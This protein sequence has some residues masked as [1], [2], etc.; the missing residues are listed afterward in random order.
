M[1]KEKA[2]ETRNLIFIQIKPKPG[3]TLKFKYFSKAISFPP[4]RIII[5]MA[6]K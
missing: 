3:P 2:L 1:C 6:D 5:P 4:F